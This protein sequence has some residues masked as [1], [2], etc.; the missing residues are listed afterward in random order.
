MFPNKFFDILCKFV[1]P[2]SSRIRAQKQLLF[3]GKILFSSQNFC[4]QSPEIQLVAVEQGIFRFGGAGA[5]IQ[6]KD[7]QLNHPFPEHVLDFFIILGAL[8][9]I[10]QNLRL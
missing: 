9:L 10:N 1:R 8:L 6:I 5:V 7:K 2:E 4:G 3:R